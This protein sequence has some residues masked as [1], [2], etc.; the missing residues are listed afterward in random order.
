MT[1]KKQLFYY[2]FSEVFH[3]RHCIEKYEKVSIE[4]KEKLHCSAFI[5]NRHSLDL[6]IVGVTVTQEIFFLWMEFSENLRSIPAHS[7]K[8]EPCLVHALN[9]ISKIC[10]EII[11]HEK[12][13]LS[14][15]LTGIKEPLTPTGWDI[16][17]RLHMGLLNGSKEEGT[18]QTWKRAHWSSQPAWDRIGSE[19]RPLTKWIWLRK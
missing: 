9:H 4:K 16:W 15:K 17:I 1:C 19:Q 10:F 2:N 6:W 7:G 3:L 11:L 13:S 5:Y 18:A 14:Q 8:D 12:S